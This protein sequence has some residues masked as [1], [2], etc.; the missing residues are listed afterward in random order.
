ML[1]KKYIIKCSTQICLEYEEDMCMKYNSFVGL[2]LLLFTHP[3]PWR[4]GWARWAEASPACG[5]SLAA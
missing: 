1:H 5:G 2:F 4:P 3:G